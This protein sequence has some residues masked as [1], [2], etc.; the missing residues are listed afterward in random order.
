MAW[1]GSRV[2]PE[3][4]D[5]L[6]LDVTDVELQRKVLTLATAAVH[7]DRHVSDAETQLLEATAR[8]WGLPQE[9]IATESA[10]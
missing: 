6:L 8:R 2:D 7:A 4:L 5:S 9:G 1:G 10:R 3:L